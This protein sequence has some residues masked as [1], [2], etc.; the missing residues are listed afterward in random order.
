MK[1]RVFSNWTFLRWMYLII[2]VLL[3]V[4]SFL[5]RQWLGIVLGS[6]FATMGLFAFGCAAGSC[7]AD[8]YKSKR[9]LQ[10][11]KRSN[12]KYK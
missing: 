3:L 9:N 6:Y 4:P 10:T 12:T 1:Q 5:E 7:S 2:G 8:L 11:E